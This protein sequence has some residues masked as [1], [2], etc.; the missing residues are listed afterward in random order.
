[1][2]IKN[3]KPHLYKKWGLNSQFMATSLVGVC[4]LP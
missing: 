1:M 3:T 4:I 2:V